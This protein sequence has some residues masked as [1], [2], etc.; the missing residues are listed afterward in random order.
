MPSAVT[1]NAPTIVWPAKPKP[2]T[3]MTSHFVSSRGRERNSASRSAEGATNRRLT[4]ERD[5]ELDLSSTSAPTGSSAP[6]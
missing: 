3:K 1:P 5:V 4:D 6:S 2:S